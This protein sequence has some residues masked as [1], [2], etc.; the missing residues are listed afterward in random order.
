MASASKPR[1]QQLSEQLQA[2]PAETARFEDIP[3]IRQIASDS[4]GQYVNGEKTLPET[5]VDFYIEESRGKSWS[6]QVECSQMFHP[7][8]R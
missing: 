2:P 3:K 4:A 1:L 6:L 5:C 8:H 7:L